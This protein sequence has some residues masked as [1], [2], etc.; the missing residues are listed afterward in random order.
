[1]EC[2]RCGLKTHKNANSRLCPES[3]INRKMASWNKDQLSDVIVTDQ[4]IAGLVDA[5][6]CFSLNRGTPMFVLGQ[7]H[8]FGRD[9]LEKISIHIGAGKVGGP[10]KHGQYQL[11][12]YGDGYQRMLDICSMHGVIKPDRQ[13]W[14]VT[15][16]WLGGF[17]AGDGCAIYNGGPNVTIT[18]WAHPEV[19]YAIRDTLGYGSV[20]KDRY[21]QCTGDNARKFAHRFKD[22]ALHKKSDLTKL[23]ELSLCTNR[24][25]HHDQHVYLQQPRAIRITNPNHFVRGEY[26]RPAS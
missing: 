5:D 6:G 21:W 4:I 10:G 26:L 23:L 2:K 7:S 8:I 13:M 20:Y 11:P 12:L 3:H 1:M 19:L 14:N 18:Q 17:F 16:E 24:L 22:F 9:V 15:D 25:G